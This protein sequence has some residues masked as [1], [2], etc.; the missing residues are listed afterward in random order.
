M[1]A[2]GPASGQKT[3]TNTRLHMC[4]GV[5]VHRNLPARVGLQ[6]N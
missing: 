3:Y 5:Y 6:A 2:Q 4:I 1:H